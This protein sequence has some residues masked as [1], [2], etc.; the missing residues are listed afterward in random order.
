MQGDAHAGGAGFSAVI[1]VTVAVLIV[2]DAVAEAVGGG[3]AGADAHVQGHVG[4]A[5]GD[6][7]GAGG[8]PGGGVGVGVD[9]VVSALVLEG[10]F[11]PGREG[12][13]VEADE[14]V[15]GGQAGK[16]V[17]ALVVGVGGGQGGVGA[18]GLAVGVELHAHAGDAGLFGGV[19]DAVAVRVVPDA[20]ADG[21]GGAADDAHVQGEVLGAGA[22]GAGGRGLAG[23]GIGVGVDVVGAGVL[24]GGGEPGREGGQIEA[25]EVVARG[26]VIEQVAAVGG[27]GGNGQGRG[28]A[29]GVGGAVQG[30]TDALD[31]GFAG[32]LQTVGVQVVPDEVADAHRL[33]VLTVVVLVV[34]DLVAQANAGHE[35][36]VVGVVV[37]PGAT[38]D[39]AGGYVA[40]GG[41]AVGVAQ[42]AVAAGVVVGRGG[43]VAAD[44][45]LVQGD[46]QF[47]G[48]VVLQIDVGAGTGQTV[49]D[50]QQ[51]GRGSSAIIGFRF[52]VIC[53]VAGDDEGHSV[54]G[55][56]AGTVDDFLYDAGKVGGALIGA[57]LTGGTPGRDA[58]PDDAGRGGGAA[59]DV[60]GGCG[61]GRGGVYVVALKGEGGVAGAVGGGVVGGELDVGVG[62]DGPGRD[63]QVGETHTHGVGLPTVVIVI[64]RLQVVAGDGGGAGVGTLFGVV[65]PGVYAHGDAAGSLGV[66]EVVVAVSIRG[67]R[68]QQGAP[69]VVQANVDV[70][71]GGFAGVLDAVI[72]AVYPDAVT[73]FDEGLAAKK[74]GVA[75]AA[76]FAEFGTLW[77]ELHGAE[78]ITAA[79]APDYSPGFEGDKGVENGGDQF[80]AAGE[81]GQRAD[82]EFAVVIGVEV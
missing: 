52:A 4:P 75:N 81:Q 55:S 29:V 31:T 46:A 37:G 38:G 40:G 66:A 74:F 1:L 49:F 17:G 43:G 19:L 21:H 58:G 72:V 54:A 30:D 45:G 27:G 20:V 16:E 44:G 64:D 71:Q 48:G 77:I 78:A 33:V 18:A 5:G 73:D 35:A 10:D 61:K 25:D 51:G 76:G 65:L 70:G 26:Q 68:G 36:E 8:G 42:V 14:V 60:V 67:G 15:A 11:V 12:T 2:P 39:E 80:V 32:A 3:V 41:L 23:G 63:G 62:D 34:P 69:G 59:G 82:G 28:G 53:A 50:D 13:Q 7:A 24:G 56:P 57:G 6:G 47:V 79:V 9:A 22:E